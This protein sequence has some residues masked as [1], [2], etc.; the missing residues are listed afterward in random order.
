MRDLAGHVAR[1]VPQSEIVQQTGCLPTNAFKRKERDLEL[2]FEKH[3]AVHIEAL[4]RA[5]GFHHQ[6][7]TTLYA[8]EL[9]Y[10]LERKGGQK[11]NPV[12]SVPSVPFAIAGVDVVRTS[13]MSPEVVRALQKA[14]MFTDA[15]MYE[16][17]PRPEV[18]KGCVNVTR[19]RTAE[20]GDAV[21][22]RAIAPSPTAPR[23]QLPP[24]RARAGGDA[25]A[26]AGG[27]WGAPKAVELEALSAERASDLLGQIAA[28]ARAQHAQAQ[29]RGRQELA[30]AETRSAELE[31][32]LAQA[33]QKEEGEEEVRRLAAEGK[34]R[35][36][37]VSAARR[38]ARGPG[39]APPGLVVKCAAGGDGDEAFLVV[40]CYRMGEGRTWRRVTADTWNGLWERADEL[41]RLPLRSRE[42]RL[43]QLLLQARRAEKRGTKRPEL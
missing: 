16:G 6:A 22:V 39:S 23:A 12:P 17:A 35:K 34:K 9:V 36:A 41:Q 19:I 43:F 29:E 8:A 32:R 31:A 5:W 28:R 37:A 10:P 24:E 1:S 7:Q 30:S 2:D 42:P 40:R 38:N 15:A 25:D 26:A 21:F 4:V 14:L 27:A 13:E 18:S 11:K 33:Q 3:D 20:P